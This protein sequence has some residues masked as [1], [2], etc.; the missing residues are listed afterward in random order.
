VAGERDRLAL[1]VLTALPGLT[2]RR[3]RTLAEATGGAAACLAAVRGGHG[4]VEQADRDLAASLR[5]G[6]L[7]ARLDEIG[8]RMAVPGDDD[9]PP[10]VL[11]LPD[12]PV[13]LFVRG[14]SVGGH[15]TAVAVVGARNCSPLGREVARA[16]GRDLAG[17]G[18]CVVSG[19]ARGIDSA[20][21][22]GALSVG[23]PTV[24]V[25]GSGIDVAYP[26]RSLSLLDRIVAGGAVVSEYP[27]GVPA[28]PFRFPAR[29][30]IVTAMS[31]AV[32]V[33]E[34]AAGSGS[35]I[36]ADFALDLGRPVFGVPGPVTSP[37]SE[38]PLTLIRDGAGLVRNAADLLMDLGRLDPGF[39]ASP[40]APDA[41]AAP[42]PLP[43]G[44]TDLE[45]RVM[46]ALAG[47]TLPEVLAADLGSSLGEVLA[48]I[49]GLEVRGLV[50][51]VGGRVERRLVPP[52]G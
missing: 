5:P 37:L 19:A 15:R 31:E 3:L 44:L 48:A 12:P 43:D 6:D 22:E 1:L 25:L 52:T 11:D 34:G 51:T 20:A 41:R 23:G 33:V 26:K 21:H 29:N 10:G 50:R 46:G 24:A 27:P 36:T 39:P 16:F 35:F 13:A 45:R 9:Y 14:G 49:V 38:A 40:G 2:A 30:R 8:A 47:P 32:L 7:S 18:A 17:A 28:Q 4:S 42:G